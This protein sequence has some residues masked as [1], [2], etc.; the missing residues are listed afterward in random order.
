M[1]KKSLEYVF[2][3]TIFAAYG[4]VEENATL[5]LIDEQNCSSLPLPRYKCSMRQPFSQLF[6]HT[7]FYSKIGGCAANE[8]IDSLIIFLIYYIF[9]L[10]I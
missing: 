10:H 4:F 6:S 7:S 2:K 5:L 1:K 8:N 9:T 3:G